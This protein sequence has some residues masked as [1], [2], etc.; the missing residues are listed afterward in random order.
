[1]PTKATTPQCDLP[2]DGLWA[3]SPERPY[4]RSLGAPSSKAVSTSTAKSE[5]AALVRF[6]KKCFEASNV[7]KRI[8]ADSDDNVHR[9]TAS[10][11]RHRKG[12]LGPPCPHE[13]HKISFAYLKEINRDNAIGKIPTASNLAGRHANKDAHSKSQIISSS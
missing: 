11:G 8:R 7:P 10:P 2:R 5:A 13:P 6:T 4:P 12:T 3:S 1:M 9:L